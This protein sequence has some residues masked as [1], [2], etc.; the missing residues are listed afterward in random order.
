MHFSE[1]LRRERWIEITRN[2]DGLTE[3]SFLECPECEE[4]ALGVK[5][6]SWPEGR[7]IDYYLSCS[8]CGASNTA[9][10]LVE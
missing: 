7:H 6:V 8:S 10:K 4:N 5:I 1:Q 3:G 9:T 2:L